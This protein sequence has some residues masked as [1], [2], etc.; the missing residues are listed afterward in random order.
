[1][2]H[3]PFQN[4]HSSPKF[5]KRCTLRRWCVF[6]DGFQNIIIHFK[7]STHRQHFQR[8]VLSVG[9]VY[10]QMVSGIFIDRNIT[11]PRVSQFCNPSC[12]IYAKDLKWICFIYLICFKFM[13]WYTIIS[14]YHM[15]DI[16]ID[17]IITPPWV[18]QFCNSNCAI[19]CKVTFEAHFAKYY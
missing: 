5:S 12:A 17:R 4:Q 16:F 7:I 1:M 13:Y 6:A 11:P 8:G 19:I 15:F 18:S 3:Y 2:Q 14:H 9:G 10:L